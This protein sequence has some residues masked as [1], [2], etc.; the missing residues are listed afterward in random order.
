M[1]EGGGK[2]ERETIKFNKYTQNIG[3]INFTSPTP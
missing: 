2:G 1:D 3:Y